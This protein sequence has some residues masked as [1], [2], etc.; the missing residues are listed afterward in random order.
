MTLTEFLL[1][2]IAEDEGHA[3]K[4]LETDRRPVL[5]LASTVNHPARLLAEVAAKRRIV[6]LHEPSS[7]PMASWT[8]CRHCGAGRGYCAHLRLLASVYADH[9][10]YDEAWQHG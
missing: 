3:R 1:A 10:D 9:A 2:R 5:S 4:L 7:H 6:A 8:N